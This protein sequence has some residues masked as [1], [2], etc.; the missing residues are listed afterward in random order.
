MQGWDDIRTRKKNSI[1]FKTQ[2]LMQLPKRV[3]AAADLAQSLARIADVLGE[4]HGLLA[5][6]VH[7][8][9]SEA[10]LAQ[11]LHARLAAFLQVP[12]G[13]EGDTAEDAVKPPSPTETCRYNQPVTAKSNSSSVSSDDRATRL[14]QLLGDQVR[15]CGRKTV[16]GRRRLIPLYSSRCWNSCTAMA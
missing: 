4:I 6:E 11:Q 7:A 15:K 5:E 14:S 3:L 1:H 9:G 12:P 13:M 16:C 2:M 10:S 8:R